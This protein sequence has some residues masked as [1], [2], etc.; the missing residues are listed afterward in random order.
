MT[1][2][3]CTRSRLRVDF[4]YDGSGFSGWAAQPGLRTVEE[5]LALAWQTILRCEEPPRLTV[6]GRTDAGVHARGAVCHLDVADELLVRL[7]GRSDRSPA[8]AAV[9]RL[10]GV[11]PGDVVVRAVQV[12][13]EGFDAR[14]SA[15]ERRYRYRLLDDPARLDPLR[16]HDT[17]VVRRP[18]DLA[19]MQEACAGLVGL[20]DFAAFCKQR[21][22]ATTIRALLEYSWVRDDEG[23]LVATVR[24]DAFCHSM[25]RALIGGAV[26]VGEGRR[27]AAWLRSVLEGARRDPGVAVMP[28]QGL[29][30][31][32][33][34]YPGDDQL[35]ARAE[36]A[37][38][39]RRLPLL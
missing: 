34:V 17:T 11:L 29:S 9:T 21:E 30:L 32:A 1:T 14:F 24:A 39:V 37:R 15:V 19:R 3:P 18:L 26:P 33:V 31:E 23:V 16:R 27:D 4:A 36:E 25:V 38:A 5:T 13:P 35:G 8:E 10:N 6:A 28:P 2:Q 7:P 12:A 20:H 22:G